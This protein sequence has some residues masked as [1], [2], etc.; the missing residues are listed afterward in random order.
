MREQ[1]CSIFQSKSWI[2]G[3]NLRWPFRCLSYYNRPTGS[4]RR[5]NKSHHILSHPDNQRTT[6]TPAWQCQSQYWFL[7]RTMW[8]TLIYP[9]INFNVPENWLR[10][11][12]FVGSSE[13][14]CDSDDWPQNSTKNKSSKTWLTSF[15]LATPPKMPKS[16]ELSKKQ[17]LEMR[18]FK[19]TGITVKSHLVAVKSVRPGSTKPHPGPWTHLTCRHEVKA[20]LL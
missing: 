7:N 9:C 5:I 15:P 8:D 10:R 6:T 13:L 2:G 4:V 18:H 20:T 1:I 14:L 11:G 17:E 16:I 12:R 3:P 19:L